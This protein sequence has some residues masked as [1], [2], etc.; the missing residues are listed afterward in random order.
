MKDFMKNR[1]LRIQEIKEEMEYLKLKIANLER[2]LQY[3]QSLNNTE[4]S[5]KYWPPN[6]YQPER[7]DPPYYI[8]DPPPGPYNPNYVGDPPYNPN[9]P[10]YVGD[11]I[12][13]SEPNTRIVSSPNSVDPDSEEYRRK[14][15]AKCET[16]VI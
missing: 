4:Y 14:Y 7:I 2:E 13:H 16:K 5:P 11:P 3:L 8:G 10:F 9:G 15:G 1:N 12:T 6:P